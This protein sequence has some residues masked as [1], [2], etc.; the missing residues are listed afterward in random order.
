MTHNHTII[1]QISV[2]LSFS[3]S[4]CLSICP[5]TVCMVR[6]KL[7][8]CVAR[9]LTM[10]LL[11]LSLYG[12]GQIIELNDFWVVRYAFTAANVIVGHSADGGALYCL[13]GG[14][15]KAV[16]YD[17]LSQWTI[18]GQPWLYRLYYPMCVSRRIDTWQIVYL[19]YKDPMSA[20]VTSTHSTGKC[21]RARVL[22]KY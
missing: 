19:S 4:V 15:H 9:N 10:F 21:A 5:K 12:C 7:D 8:Q 6:F 18:G 13:I 3:L 17:G 14:R 22:P 2:R 11:Y 16:P 20:P 1:P